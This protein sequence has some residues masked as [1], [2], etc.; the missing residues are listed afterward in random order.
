MKV[1][2]IVT[3]IDGGVLRSGASSYD[4]A[5]VATLDPFTLISEEGDMEWSLT[6]E[7]KDFISHGTAP[8]NI[9]V[10][11]LDRMKRDGEIGTFVA[12]KGGFKDN[13]GIHS[14]ILLTDDKN[15]V[16]KLPKF[17]GKLFI[18]K[19]YNQGLVYLDEGE[20]TYSSSVVKWLDKVYVQTTSRKRADRL[21]FEY[22]HEKYPQYKKYVQLF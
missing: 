12:M 16:H 1:R 5:I 14:H 8:K 18:K 22:L 17:I 19:Y 6:V 3:P 7:Q 15:I 4:H 11:V 2:D 10:K 21:T 13:S 9:W 20:P